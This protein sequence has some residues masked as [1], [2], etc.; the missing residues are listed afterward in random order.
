MA[1]T[2][3]SRAQVRTVTAPLPRAA[4]M[5][6]LRESIARRALAGIGT[7]VDARI[8]RVVRTGTVLTVATEQPDGYF[9]YAVDSFRLPTPAETDVDQVDPCAPGQWILADQLGDHVEGHVDRMIA[10]ATAYAAVIQ[11][12]VVSA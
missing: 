5:V 11:E 2:D 4:R 1:S 12:A 8:V 10:E 3:L 9:R 6:Q 7:P